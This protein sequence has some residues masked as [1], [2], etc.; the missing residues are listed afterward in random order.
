MDP[1]NMERCHQIV[2]VLNAS[3]LLDEESFERKYCTRRGESLQP[4]FYIVCW[5]DSSLAQG[6]DETASYIG[7]YKMQ[8]HAKL[9]LEHYLELL[10]VNS[11]SGFR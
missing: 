11:R 3:R 5:P 8:S 9:A 1:S 2:K 6:Y 4:G 10:R 7:P